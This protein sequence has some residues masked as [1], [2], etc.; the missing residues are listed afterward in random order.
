MARPKKTGL[1]YFPNN[2]I[3]D[4][5]LELIIAEFGMQGLGIINRLWQAIYLNG[6]YCEWNDDA[7]LLFSHKNGVSGKAVSEVI[8]ACFRREI[9]DKEK[10]IKYG[11]LTSQGIQKRYF[12]ACE[13]RTSIEV[14]E[15]YLLISAPKNVVFSPK[16]L[17]YGAET[18]VFSPKT[19]QR[20]LDKIKL[21]EIKL[22]SSSVIAQIPISADEENKLF[23]LMGD[24]VYHRYLDK[25]AAFIRSGGRYKNL[26]QTMLE[27]YGED[28]G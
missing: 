15:D 21:D 26:Y 12:E 20:K 5:S 1:V 2:T 7:A 9:F 27:W 22:V 10:F 8:N 13:K 6:Y 19:Q 23:E 25:A 28:Y 16:T 14:N 11:I 24:E 3:Y 18:P 17:V 4:T